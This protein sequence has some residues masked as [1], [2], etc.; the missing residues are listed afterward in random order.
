MCHKKVHITL[1]LWQSDVRVGNKF[2]TKNGLWNIWA[3]ICPKYPMKMLYIHDVYTEQFWR[4]WGVFG[5]GSV[6]W[7]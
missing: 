4:K 5:V 2:L 7:A 6:D 3:A 1:L